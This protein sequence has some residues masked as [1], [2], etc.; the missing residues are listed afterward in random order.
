MFGSSVSARGVFPAR[1]TGDLVGRDAECRQL[2]NLLST[3]RAGRSQVL[4]VHGEPGVGKTAMLEYAIGSA[5]GFQVARA[6]GIES[7]MELPFAGLHQL[8]SPLLDRLPLLPDPQREALATAF[9]LRAGSPPDRLLVGLAALTLLCEAAERGPLLCVVDDVQWLDRASAQTFAFV[10]R[11]LLAD[12]VGVVFSTRDPDGEL[13]RLPELALG[14]LRPTDARALLCSLPG[15]PL[16]LE[17]RDRIVAE[18]HGNPLALHESRHTLTP[19]ELSGGSTFPGSGPL[20]GRIE[21]SFRRRL[22]QLPP[23][24]QE[25]LLVA[26]AE[27]VGHAVL[28]A[29]AAM[30]LGVSSDAAAPAVDAGLI[31]LGAA[32]RFRHPLVRSAAYHLAPQAAREQ[33][34]RALAQATDPG[35]D[36]DRRAWHRALAVS[37]PDEDVAGELERS[38]TRAQAR[39]GL[40]AAA[41]FLERA[42]ALT[43]DGARRAERALVAA[44]AKVQAGAFTDAVSLLA[45]AEA[46][47]LG[48]LGR[49]RADL[50]R[51]QIAFATRRGNDAGPL[52]LKA[53]KRLEPIDADLARA[54]YRDAL[55]A[56]MVAGRLSSADADVVRVAQAASAAPPP[57]GPPTAADLLLDGLAANTAE[58]CAAGLPV[59]R[60]ALAT[61]RADMA[62]EE[63]LLWLSLAWGA[64]WDTWDDERCDTLSNRYVQL[65]REVG[66]L[67]EL[68]IALNARANV[69]CFTG[70]LATAASMVEE[71]QA[72]IDATGITFSPYGAM[73]LA[74]WRGDHV[75]ASGV[76]D[77][78]LQEARRRG[79]GL[80]I[81]V[82]ELANAVLHNGLGRYDEALGAAQRA[83]EA[84]IW[85]L[86]LT[87]WALA[88]LVEAAVRCGKPRIAT[89]AFER[90]RPS[91]RASGTEWA[92]GVEA[93][94]HALLSGRDRAEPL[95]RE[96]IERLGRT[97]IRTELARAHLV[98]GEWL[99][100]DNRRVDARE[101]LRAG[102]EMLS[103]M[104]IA[105]F[106]ERARVE[107]AAT[108]EIV[109]KRTFDTSDELTP[110]EL[111]IARLA[112]E[113]RSNPEIGSQLFISARTVEWHLRK[114]FTKLTVSS[115]RELPDVLRRVG[116][117]SAT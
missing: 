113:G 101:Q 69:L 117:D 60:R 78:S 25:F 50:V 116:L 107:L 100:R 102:Y 55:V 64:A 96:A 14:G 99:R 23:A 67:N 56:A 74:A 20:S 9:G 90:L 42:T 21:E 43:P 22:A 29:R 30:L 18:A 41:S 73:A 71:V 104:G 80:G 38:A 63:E 109:R 105:A 44:H 85:E 37:V 95:Y 46:T 112:A 97:R 3:V 40:A 5:S 26:A 81:T 35:T 2:D 54:T 6:T 58:G 79:E 36:P 82:A 10:A 7:E 24:A 13:L 15:A 8:F 98:F 114:V 115:R 83:T 19:G 11:R 75:G 33:A 52:L 53:A 39:G 31:E 72:A 89:E 70:D 106:A 49:A 92:L 88:E 84:P 108:G 34:H 51:A 62:A 32:V 17:V 103:G 93:R 48:E 16:D 27:P 94:A 76:L 91:T 1:M 61:S 110:Q 57:P 87:S 28:V 47:E 111:Q 68:P 45:T 4:V 59:L 12:P 65:A 86:G 77:A 66:A